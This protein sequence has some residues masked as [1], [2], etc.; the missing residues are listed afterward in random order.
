MNE[1]IEQLD[2]N[3]SDSLKIEK[4]NGKIYLMATPADEHIDVQVNLAYIFTDYFRRNKKRCAARTE[5]RLDIDANN[6]FKPDLMILCYNNSEHT[7]LIVIEI[8]SNSTRERDLGVKMEKYA[9]LGIKEYWI[10]TW[11]ISAIDIYLLTADKSYKIYKSYSYLR[12]TQF[13]PV[14]IPEL[15]VNIDDV[16][17]FVK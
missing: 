6:F 16:F 14:S 8:L 7:P 15:T 11:E 1:P 10:I 12:E 4:I 3:F 2:Y 13:S 5:A 17:Y 9:Q